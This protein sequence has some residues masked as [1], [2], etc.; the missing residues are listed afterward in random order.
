MNKGLKKAV[1]IS[2]E[3]RDSLQKWMEGP[4]SLYGDKISA[5]FAIETL[6]LLERR[7]KD[8]MDFVNCPEC[9]GDGKKNMHQP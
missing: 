9:G 3:M 8:S 6:K 7:V 2:N 1:E 4:Q 5:Q